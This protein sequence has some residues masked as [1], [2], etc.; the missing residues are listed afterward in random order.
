MK[1]R[2]S[3]ALALLGWYLMAPPVVCVKHTTAEKVLEL[4]QPKCIVDATAPLWEWSRLR[5]AD[6]AGECE[7]LSQRVFEHAYNT[8]DVSKRKFENKYG[9]RTTGPPPGIK[10]DER[11]AKLSSIGNSKCI[12]SDDP[13]LKPR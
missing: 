4:S 5:P 2:H 12:A 6:S 10:L 13:G 7:E 1:V 11:E 3:A 9:D 8:E